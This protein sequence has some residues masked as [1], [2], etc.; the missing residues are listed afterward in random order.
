MRRNGTLH[1]LNVFSLKI[2]FYRDIEEEETWVGVIAAI[3]KGLKPYIKHLKRAIVEEDIT[4]LTEIK[5]KRISKFDID[6]A[7]QKNRGS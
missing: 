7:Q 4:R 3:G 2:E 5:I 6:K 1:L